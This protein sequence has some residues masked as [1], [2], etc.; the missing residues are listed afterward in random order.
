M[1]NFF[2]KIKKTLGKTGNLLSSKILALF[3]GKID[4]ETLDELNRI[5]FEADLGTKI[6]QDLVDQVRL[7]VQKNP[8]IEKA[9]LLDF[10]KN[11]LK[12]ILRSK[13][14]SLNF[15][16]DGPSCFLIVG[17]NGSGKTTSVAKLAKYFK[18]QNKKVL[19][20]AADTYRAAAVN[21]L[22]TWA[23]RLNVD[24]VKGQM[25]ADPA[26]VVFDAMNAANSRGSDIVII[27]TAG[28]LQVKTDLM[29]ELKK[30][31]RVITKIS[32]K[33]PHE[34][35]LVVDATI[36]QNA[37]DQAKVF[38]QFTPLSGLIVTKLD[39]STKGGSSI[40]IQEQCQ[41]A[42]K[43]IGLGESWDDLQPFD[44]ETFVEGLLP[45]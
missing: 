10:L 39:G 16:P 41:I 12:K 11:Q 29:N 26:A 22:D 31:H 33:A 23:E 15:A 1:L 6:C 27:D 42:I 4:E 37:V 17:I 34:T 44:A 24:I 8:K 45:L 18:D 19:I 32:P 28:R 21:Q 43:F 25:G 14:C 3:N 30:I 35:L 7:E 20:V 36:G 5:L 13:T 2:S 38:N 40:A 9:E